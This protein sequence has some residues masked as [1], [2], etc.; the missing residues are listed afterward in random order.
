MS[1]DTFRDYLN[2][3]LGSIDGHVSELIPDTAELRA[4]RINNPEL[5]RDFI[6]RWLTTIDGHIVD[7]INGGGIHPGPTPP[8]PPINELLLAEWDFTQ[9]TDPYIDKING[10]VAIPSNITQDSNGLY[11]PT[12]KDG[13]LNLVNFANYIWKDYAC[14]HRLEIDVGNSDMTNTNNNCKF[15]MYH[16]NYGFIY[17]GSTYNYWSIYNNGWVNPTTPNT[18]VNYFNNKTLKMYMDNSNMVI[19]GAYEGNI[20]MS[21]STYVKDLYIGSN[22]SSIFNTY[23]KGLR[24]YAKK[25]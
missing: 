9:N 10:K 23:I 5:Y 24:L 13:F 18:D 15:I 11:F 6:D 3:K 16:L 22:S 19:D 2:N 21:P 1:N 12:T 8:V 20:N 7:I 4:M 17:R 14:Y 25:N